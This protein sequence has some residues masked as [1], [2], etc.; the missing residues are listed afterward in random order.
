M[1]RPREFDITDVIEKAMAVFWDLGYENSA[2]PDLLAATGLSRGSLYKAF[3]DKKAL[4]IAALKHYGD[5][6][7]APMGAALL[8]PLQRDGAARIKAVLRQIPEAVRHGDRRGCLLCS[9]AAGRAAREP[10]IAEVIDAHLDEIEAAFDSAVQDSAL[11]MDGLARMLTAQYV[12]FRTL[13]RAGMPADR[14]DE[15]IDALMRVLR[16][17]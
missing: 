1:G 8:D 10:E 13:A 15:A 11:E 9:A 17:T 2:L 7:V 4:F 12:G 14:L 5:T 3:D 6:E 16:R